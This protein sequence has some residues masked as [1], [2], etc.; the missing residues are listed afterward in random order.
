METMARHDAQQRAVA[1]PA[2]KRRHLTDRFSSIQRSML[3]PFDL[4]RKFAPAAHEF[5]IGLLG[6]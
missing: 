6:F 4:I 1:C 2:F 5:Q 3:E